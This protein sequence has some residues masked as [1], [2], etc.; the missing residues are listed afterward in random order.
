MLLSINAPGSPSSPLHTT[1]FCFAFCFFTCA[2]LRP[3]GNLSSAS[4]K[5]CF[6]YFIYNFI[7]GHVK[8]RFLQRIISPGCKVFGYGCGVNLTT[9]FQYKTGL[10]L[11]KGNFI[12]FFVY[13]SVLFIGK[14]FYMFPATIVLSTISSQSSALLWCTDNLQAQFLQGVPFHK[15]HG[16]RFFHAYGIVVWF[17][18]QFNLAIHPSL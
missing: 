6:S 9:V 18:F 4:T 3:A 2:H 17:F 10:L 16:T 11:V 13:N 7:T 5:I 14:P 1:Y 15:N 8:Q 12:L